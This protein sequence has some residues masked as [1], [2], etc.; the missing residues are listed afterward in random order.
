MKPLALH[1]TAF[2][3]REYNSGCLGGMKN[4]ALPS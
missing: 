2:V 1:T 3:T 4:P